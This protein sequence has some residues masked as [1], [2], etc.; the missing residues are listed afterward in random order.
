MRASDKLVRDVADYAHSFTQGRVALSDEPGPPYKSKYDAEMVW[1]GPSAGRRAIMFHIGA[2]VGWSSETG[3]HIPQDV[4]PL[5]DSLLKAYGGIR[6]AFLQEYV[7]GVAHGLDMA[8]LS[9]SEGFVDLRSPE[10]S[11]LGN[12]QGFDL[13]IAGA[14][15]AHLGWVKEVPG[16]YQAGTGKTMGSHGE[17]MGSMIGP[18]R[19]FCS[20]A[21]RDLLTAHGRD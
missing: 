3:I 10:L 13:F 16:G 15:G 11:H 8:V 5:F 12:P 6:F 9:L 14:D 20:H 17:F 18:V 2:V 19:R 4:V 21:A 1:E 7:A